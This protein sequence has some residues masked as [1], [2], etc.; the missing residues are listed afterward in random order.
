M[1]RDDSN[2][3]EQAQVLVFWYHPFLQQIGL[4]SQLQVLVLKYL[5]CR[6]N[7]ENLHLQPQ[8]G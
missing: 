3:G 7:T 5:G 4:H 1:S 6:Q 8:A 2:S